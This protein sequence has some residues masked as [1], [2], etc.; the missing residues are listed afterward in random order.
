MG[1][2]RPRLRETGTICT[3]T[4][5]V[6]YLT[7]YMEQPFCF[8]LINIRWVFCETDCG[9]LVRGPGSNMYHGVKLD[10][11]EASALK[12]KSSPL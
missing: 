2:V 1:G 7:I 12:R 9:I 5:L 4:S 6:V 10:A 3:S 8:N 11:E